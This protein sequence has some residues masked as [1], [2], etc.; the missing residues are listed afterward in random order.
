MELKELKG[1]ELLGE[2]DLKDI[3]SKGYILRHRKTKARV[4]VILNDDDNKCFSIG[5]KTPPKDSTGVAHIIEHSVLEGSEKFPVK[6]P[7]VELCKSSLNT[8]LN[9][10]T[11]PD[12]TL[13]PVASCNDLDLHNLIHVYMD[14]VLRPNIYRNKFIFLQEGWRYEMESRE[15]ELTINGI[16]YNEMKG[17][18]S[19]V[20]DIMD[21][22]SRTSLYPDTVYGIESGGDPKCIPDLTYEQFLDFHGKYY[23]PSNSYI[24]LYGNVDAAKELD[25]IDKEYLD[26]Y[27]YLEID[28][29]IDSE[30]HFASPRSEVIDYPISEE[31]SEEG[32]YNFT[33]NYSIETSLD[34][35]L[36]D[37]VDVLDYA[38]CS[39]PG[40]PLK[41]ALIKAG[42]GDDVYSTFESG[43]YQPYFSIVAKGCNGED[44][45]EFEKIVKDTLKD[46]A[47]NGI[48]KKALRA[49]LN[50]YEFKYREADYG[51]DPK[52]LMYGIQMLDSW[53]YDDAEPFTN[54]LR[55]DSYDFLKKQV[56]TDYFENLIRKY[57][58]E[59]THAS[60]V[61]FKP[62]KGLVA[63]DEEALRDKLAH[64]KKSLSDEEI[65]AIVKQTEDL[66]KWQ[67]EED[68][69]EALATIPM[70]SKSDLNREARKF[71]N[72]E[73]EA[74]GIKTLFHDVYTNK[75]AYLRLVF[76]VSVPQEDLP[77]LA[78]YKNIIGLVNTKN[79][80]YGE[81]FS[82]IHLATG[83]ISSVLNIYPRVDSDTTTFTYDM[84]ARVMYDKVDRAFELLKEIMFDSDFKDKDRLR[85]LINELYARFQSSIM[86]AGH[87]F[88]YLRS[89]T[90]TSKAAYINDVTDG[91][92]FFENLE[93]WYKDFDS[94]VD[95]IISKIDTISK[96]LFR[97]DN[98][99]LDITCDEEGYEKVVKALPI[100]TKA[101]YSADKPKA[102][103][104]LTLKNEKQ[105]LKN[106]AQVQYVACGGNFRE[107]GIEYTGVINV[108]K[109]ILSYD[110]LWSEVRVK[111]GAYGCMNIISRNGD[112]CFV[113]HRD[114]NLKETIEAFENCAD[115]IESFEAD[116]LELT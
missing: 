24:Y 48:D 87:V 73:R 45:D 55:N 28:S 9:A 37:A 10:L 96:D 19:N 75:I 80:N 82:E 116:D 22:Y 43:I 91:M 56:D 102:E 42:I 93:R 36:M 99:L 34:S 79:Y 32:N 74:N 107:K 70:L 15:D 41:E 16:V 14:A 29:S 1:Y 65:E 31:E 106:S 95:E 61:A 97:A 92:G 94:C 68:T 5:F 58:I 35:I 20:D 53:L 110:Y 57:F 33:M 88:A 46:L 30:P 40:A 50:Y 66:K 78:L 44:R 17:A 52:G 47:D 77:Y 8:F 108:L 104:K 25:F 85:E 6:D 69:P 21:R 72:E 98:L 11:F 101:L 111:G 3:N 27:D 81:L 115:Y 62:V 26:K 39:V 84:K 7:F 38:L 109:V 103:P 23:H 64:I 100:F 51:S 54:I 86:S 67:E 60:F 59:N 114:P 13:Y 112:G 2:R 83:G 105:G 18:F 76:D 113:S 63:K 4:A 71:I 90:G 49:G 89:L 12:K